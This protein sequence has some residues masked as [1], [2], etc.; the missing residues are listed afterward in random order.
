MILYIYF[1]HNC[2]ASLQDV[3]T[4]AMAVDILRPDE[5]GHMNGLMWGSKLVG[6]GAGAWALSLVINAGGPGACAVVQIALLLGIMIIPIM[7]LERPGEKRFPWSPG[8]AM[9]TVETAVGNPLELL[10]AFVR[11]FSLTTTLVYIVFA[12]AKIIGHGVN[13]VVTNTLYTQHLSP[14]WTD[15]QFTA[16]SGLYATIPIIV[17]AV[18]GGFLA[19]RCGR[20]FVLVVGY[21]GYALA[22]MIFALFPQMWNQ[23]WFAMTYVLSYE[24]LSAIGAVG[25][26]SMAMR[27][28]WTKAAATVFTTFLTLSNVSHVIGNWMAGP[29]RSALT[30]AEYGDRANMVSYELTFWFV[31]IVSLIPILLL[32]WVRPDEVDRAASPTGGTRM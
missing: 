15:V 7:I 25:F 2:F 20:R 31:G 28:S 5:Q 24:T 6:K 19:D 18:G 10:K 1:V 23:G 26:L 14:K 17:G 3:C 8:Q 9:G 16:A 29:V 12:L 32:I 27:I 13:E 21:G 11:A 30:F 4:D 22:A